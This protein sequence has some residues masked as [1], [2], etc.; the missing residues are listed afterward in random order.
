MLRDND[1]LLV[2][3]DFIQ[4]AFLPGAI[5]DHTRRDL[6]DDKDSV[7]VFTSANALD[8]FVLEMAGDLPLLRGRRVA[9]TSPYTKERAL[10]YFDSVVAEGSNALE[11][12]DAIIEGV[13][14]QAILFYCCGSMAREAMPRRLRE[15]GR[16]VREIVLYRT[17][18]S[19]LAIEGNFDAVLFFSPS[20]VNAW[21]RSNQPDAS[22]VLFV[23]GETTASAIPG[24][25][26]GRVRV[27]HPSSQEE[28]VRSVIRHFKK[29]NQP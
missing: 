27:C 14:A 2:E 13:E 23:T 6:L 16:E 10:K 7:L 12:A 19:P 11:L 9:A 25:Y 1:L 29:E 20:A 22:T 3:R 15:A 18:E 26:K 28:M 8:A 5:D 24:R 4:I 17:E 21:F